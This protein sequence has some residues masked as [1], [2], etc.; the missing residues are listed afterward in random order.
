MATRRIPDPKIVGSIPTGF[1]FV[2]LY[3]IAYCSLL[4]H[5]SVS[6]WLRSWF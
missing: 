6:E 1:I 5:D 3:D 2:S 4:H